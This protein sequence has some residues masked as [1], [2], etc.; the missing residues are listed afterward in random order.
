MKTVARVGL[1]VVAWVCAGGSVVSFFGPMMA[2]GL[3]P[4]LPHLQLDEMILFL[5]V[6][7]GA[8]VASLLA[9]LPKPRPH[10]G[11]YA[12]VAPVLLFCVSLVAYV[13]HLKSLG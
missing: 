11:F 2:L 12:A 5:L 13:L 9:I 8:V 10:W 3:S 4:G 7:C 6:P 1:S